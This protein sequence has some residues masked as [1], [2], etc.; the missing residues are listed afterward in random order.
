MKLRALTDVE[1]RAGRLRAGALPAPIKALVGSLG[2]IAFRLFRSGRSFEFTGKKY[3]YLYDGYM[4]TWLTERCVEIPIVYEFVENRQGERILEIGNVLSHYYPVTHDIVDK[5]EVAPGVMNADAVD[6]KTEA[7]Y[8]L[9]VSVSTVEHIGFDEE[10][11]QPGKAKRAVD[12]LLG[13]L[14]PGGVMVLTVPLG[15]NPEID[16]LLEGEWGSLASIYYLKKVSRLN[17]W[18][19]T[20]GEEARRA[21]EERRHF[22]LNAI[23]VLVFEGSDRA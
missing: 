8:D 13:M 22:W 15:Y 20:D 17:E 12:N 1:S 10:P 2:S 5:Y 23:A 11:R 6:L 16:N 14:S 4:L 21:T 19:E 7:E 3:C 18:E 9:I